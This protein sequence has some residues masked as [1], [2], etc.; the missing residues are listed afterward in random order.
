MML[1]VAGLLGR[2]ETWIEDPKCI[3]ISFPGFVDLLNELC[4]EQCV[5]S[6]SWH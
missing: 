6:F 1:V 5:E 4:L 3:G 2:E